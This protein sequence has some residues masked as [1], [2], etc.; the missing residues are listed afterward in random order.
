MTSPGA[1]SL[2]QFS[3]MQRAGVRAGGERGSHLFQTILRS[4][5]ARRPDHRQ[6]SVAPAH[7]G[8]RGAQLGLPP[9]PRLSSRR[10]SGRR[11]AAAPLKHTQAFTP[12]LPTEASVPREEGGTPGMGKA[13]KLRVRREESENSEGEIQVCQNAG[14][15]PGNPT[16]TSKIL[17]PSPTTSLGG[18]CL[19]LRRRW[20]WSIGEGQSRKGGQ[21]E[22]SREGCP[23][24]LG[25]R[26]GDPE[27]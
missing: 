3:P 8:R 16:K 5:S 4:L 9:S 19:G 26:K 11:R 18:V 20:G 7:C 14:R 23:G 21:R 22:E 27:D 15:V 6:L 2:A 17:L 10:Q 1:L 25:A 12:L 13:N 24:S